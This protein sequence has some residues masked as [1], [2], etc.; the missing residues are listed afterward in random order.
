MLNSKVRFVRNS[1]EK[2]YPKMT[3][4]ESDLVT[5]ALYTGHAVFWQD[6]VTLVDANYPMLNTVPG[7]QVQQ[8]DT[9]SE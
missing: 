8:P 6:G 3:Q 2:D 7:Y 9:L 1:Y 4:E 5:K